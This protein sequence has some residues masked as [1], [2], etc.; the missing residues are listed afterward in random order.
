MRGV[1]ELGSVLKAFTIAMGLDEGASLK[2]QRIDVATPVKLG[3]FVIKDHHKTSD[4]TLS[5]REIF[6]HSSN[7]GAARIARQ[8]GG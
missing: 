5:V 4:G 1:Y 7:V 3:R 6:T 2:G 8:S